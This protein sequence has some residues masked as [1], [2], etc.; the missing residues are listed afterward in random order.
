MPSKPIERSEAEMNL[1][2]ETLVANLG[3]V[4]ATA[5]A[6]DM[7]T[8]TLRLLIGRTPMLQEALEEVREDA[9]DE[10]E[11]TLRKL[12]RGYKQEPGVLPPDKTAIIFFL[13]TQGRNR[14]YQE[15]IEVAD[16]SHMSTA[17]VVALAQSLAEKAQDD[18]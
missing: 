12:M 16:M 2:R 4:K 3:V 15:R 1:I 17:E 6:L 18:E 11:V 13:K 10:A 7:P 9:L 8:Q 14:G 5:R